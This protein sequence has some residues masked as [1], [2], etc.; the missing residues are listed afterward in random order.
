MTTIIPNTTNINR[1]ISKKINTFRTELF[2]FMCRFFRI[3]NGFIGIKKSATIIPGTMPISAKRLSIFN[4]SRLFE[5]IFIVMLLLKN[6]LK[7]G[8]INNNKIILIKKAR[9][10]FASVSDMKRENN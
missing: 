1:E 4:R 7:G 10:A 5:N 9:N 3:K 6:S 8:I 2:L